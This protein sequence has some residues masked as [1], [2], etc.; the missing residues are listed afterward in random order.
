MT[1][2]CPDLQPDGTGYWPETGLWALF[3]LPRSQSTALF[4]AFTARDEFLCLHEPFCSLADT[5]SVILPAA[6]EGQAGTEVRLTSITALANHIAALVRQRRVFLKETTDTE[7]EGLA[8]H[9]ILAEARDIACLT[10]DPVEAIASHLKLRPEASLADLGYGHLHRL[11]TKL[12]SKGIPLHLLRAEELAA[13]P[14]ASLRR[15]CRAAGIP[16]HPAMLDWPAQDRPEWQRTQRW[17]LFAAQSTGF[18]PA[19]PQRTD[20]DIS[21]AVRAAAAAVAADHEAILAR[22]L[23]GTRA[24]GG[25]S[26]GALRYRILQTPRDLTECFCSLCR[27]S[28]GATR[29]AWGTVDVDAFILSGSGFARHA[30]SPTCQRGFCMTC[31]THLTFVDTSRPQEI[32]F[33]LASLDCP[34]VHVPDT[35]LHVA[36]RVAWDCPSHGR[37]PYSAGRGTALAQD[38]PLARPEHEQTP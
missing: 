10:R 12:D 26:C 38:A 13:D 7:L 23:R 21:P 4:R 9:P 20:R 35:A 6:E 24:E 8:T 14:E 28:S 34:D 31:G 11:I 25:C 15:Y 32:D 33:T 27:R 30:T 18:R 17:H 29:L 3:A 22:R 2:A 36:D 16:F 5:G 37:L 19:G 1:A